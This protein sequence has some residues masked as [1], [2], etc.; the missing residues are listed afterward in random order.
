MK[1]V[2]TTPTLTSLITYSFILGGSKY[3]VG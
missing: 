3:E 2:P 1:P